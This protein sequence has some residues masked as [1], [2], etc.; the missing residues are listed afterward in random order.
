[1]TRTLPI[2]P[3]PMR[4]RMVFSAAAVMLLTVLA[5]AAGARQTE[6]G[7][8][9]P[10]GIVEAAAT[11]CFGG[12]VIGALIVY[13]GGM[14]AVAPTAGMFC[15]LSV[16]LTAVSAVTTRLTLIVDTFLGQP[17]TEAQR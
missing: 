12:A 13:A 3:P 6:I 11:S 1:M 7:R 9:A 16:A 5:P 15:G 8:T 4:G 2:S 17:T 14:S 10:S